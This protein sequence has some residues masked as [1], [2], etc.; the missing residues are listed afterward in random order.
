MGSGSFAARVMHVKTNTDVAK[1]QLKGLAQEKRKLL[2]MPP[3]IRRSILL[4]Q[5]RQKVADLQRLYQQDTALQRKRG[6]L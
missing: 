5:H 6:R 2:A 1:E 3:S 4:E